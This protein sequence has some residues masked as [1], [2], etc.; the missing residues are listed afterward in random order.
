MRGHRSDEHGNVEEPWS[1]RFL[2]IGE[3]EKVVFSPATAQAETMKHHATVGNLRISGGDFVGRAREIVGVIRAFDERDARRVAIYGSGGLGKTELALAVARWY[4]EREHVG[5]VLW[6]SA[7]HVEGEYKLR[8]LASLLGIAARVFR[9]PITEQSLF[10]DQKQIVRDFLAVNR[11]LVMLDNWETIEPHH[12][13]E[14]WDFAM[15]LS[16]EVRVLVTTRDVLPATQARNIELDTLAPNDAAELFINI[17]RNTGYFERNPNRSAEEAVALQSICNRLSGYPLAIEVVA[18]QTVSRTLTEIW[19]DLQRV[20]KNVLES[21]DEIDGKPRGIWSSIDLSYNVL[22]PSE[23]TIFRRMSVFLGPAV[24]EDIGAVTEAENAIAGLDNLVKRSLVRMREGAYSLLPIVRDYAQDKVREAGEDLRVL[25]RRAARHYFQKPTIEDALTT[26]DHLFELAAQFGEKDAA[27]AF[28][29]Y[30]QTFYYDL[31]RIGYWADA[32]SKT[33]QLIAMARVLSD[34]QI[35]TQAIGEMGTRYYEIG[36]YEHA[37]NLHRQAQLLAEE[38]N[39]KRG[40]RAALHHLGMIA[41][42]RGEYPEAARL[43]EASREISTELQD[44]LGAS[45]SLLHLGNLQFLQG[46]LIEAE[47]LYRQSLEIKERLGDKNGIAAA[48]H[49]LANIQT[50]H[51]KFREAELL[52]RQCLEF[53]K[54]QRDKSGIARILH[55]LGMVAQKQHEYDAAAQFFEESLEIET[56][57]GDKEGI[58]T[59]LGQLGQFYY[60]QGQMKNALNFSLKALA[61]CDELNSR[62]RNMAL[63]DVNQ[64]RQVVGDVQFQNWLSELST[65]AARINNLLKEGERAR[66]ESFNKSLELLAQA[67][68]AVIGA[69]KEGTE[70]QQAEL[71]HELAKTEAGAREQNLS[72]LEEFFAV[73]LGLLKGEDVTN[74]IAQLPNPLKVIAEQAQ[75]AC[76]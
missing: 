51:G 11:G 23:Q 41:Q 72:D 45:K 59:T 76:Q 69:R 30:I 16:E 73:L 39:D 27:R 53:Q 15:S 60:E 44:E 58:A 25:H 57:L 66:E 18:G 32:R 22:P 1:N 68:E 62:N 21:R 12:R 28:A 52:L 48:L 49:G 4:M 75:A 70:E 35:E 74:R 29:E 46:H 5:V 33:E 54:E 20:P 14:I 6:A 43:F 63:A 31:V 3:A 2:V 55:Q 24:M 26:S 8:D 61:L 13:R 7:S 37:A 47:Q 19:G 9:L 10:E 67:A 36:E 56:E 65:D 71:A 34:K 17:A 42:A 50:E 40:V 38:C 64:V